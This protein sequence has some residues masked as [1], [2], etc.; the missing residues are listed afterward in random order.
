M[1]LRAPTRDEID[2]ARARIRGIALRTPLVRLKHDGPDE[3]YC[4]LEQLQPIGSFKIRCGANALL[5]LP[6]EVRR[7]GVVT[8]SAGNFAQ[9]LGYAAKQIG[10][11]VTSVV[12][13]SAATSKLQALEK[14]GVALDI[15]SY[16]DW[17]RVMEAP[18]ANGFGANFI[19][20][21]MEPAVLAGNA[22]IGL[23]LIEDLP[24]MANVL[25][26]YGGGGL[27]VGIAAAVKAYRPDIRVFAVETEA[28]MPVAAAFQAGV[29][30]TVEMKPSFVTGMGSRRV[31]DPMWPLVQSLL[32]GAVST[33]LAETASAIRLLVERHH[34][35]A[36]GAGAA[37]VAA[38]LAGCDGP[39]VC[40]ISGGH[41]DT[42]HLQAILAHS[43]PA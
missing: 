6:D 10:V 38:A 37:P 43:I 12:P 42:T 31:L 35:V 4:K 26:P 15:R 9:G 23:E 33:T 30:V 17:W 40:I 39:T 2:A 18:H 11:R 34:V 29:P 8:A 27:A 16:E 3:I 41:L 32:D 21:V 1:T 22:T 7:D 19:H 5:S 36:E 13:D 14:L 25:V 20:P 28:A 24:A